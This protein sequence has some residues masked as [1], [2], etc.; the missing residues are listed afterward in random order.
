MKVSYSYLPRQF[1][2]PD[3]ILGKIR[4]LV[5]RGDFTLGLT[6]EK[7]EN[8]FAE[9]IGSK[10]AIGVGSGTDALFLSLKALGI[11]DAEGYRKDEVSSAAYSDGSN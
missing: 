11:G 4:E 1:S 3:A 2:N 9:F 7:F 10:Y 8:E 6:L 5:I